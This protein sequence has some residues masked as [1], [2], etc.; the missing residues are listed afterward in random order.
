[1]SA[2]TEAR[3]RF[4]DLSLYRLTV[5]HTCF[6][7]AVLSI[8]KLVELKSPHQLIQFIPGLRL[9]LSKPLFKRSRAKKS[10]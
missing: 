2:A 6:W 5:V 1:M 4:E 9:L 7:E 8:E 10:L 3:S